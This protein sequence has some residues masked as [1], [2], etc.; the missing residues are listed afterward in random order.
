MSQKRERK[1]RRKT[2]PVTFD[3]VRV[4][5]LVLPKAEEGTSYGTPGFK[6][7]GTLFARFHQDGESLVV[8]IDQNERSMRIKADPQTYYITDHYLNYPWILV[9]IAS[10]DHDDLRELLEE[11]WRLSAPSGFAPPT[12][13]SEEMSHREHRQRRTFS[14]L[15]QIVR[16]PTVSERLTYPV[17][18]GLG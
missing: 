12:T 9:R 10:V 8:R 6:V 13:L 16:G 15:D 1:Y 5:A 4:L 11:A 3:K 7:G 18:S 2:E 17:Q 14:F